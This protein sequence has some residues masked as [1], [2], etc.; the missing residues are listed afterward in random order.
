MIARRFEWLRRVLKD[1]GIAM[2]NQRCLSMHQPFGADDFSAKDLAN[3]LMTEANPEDGR[4]FS[5]FT[6][7]LLAPAGVFRPAWA[8]RDT[9]PVWGQLAD[10]SKCDLVVP[11]HRHLRA[12]LS[13]VLDEIIGERVVVIDDEDVHFS[14]R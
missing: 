4:L 11:F 8:G 3:A 12:E 14:M 6:N 2:L 1:A 10:L 13:K 9:N 5:Q 7:D